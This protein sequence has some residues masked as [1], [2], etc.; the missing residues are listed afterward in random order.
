MKKRTLR[1]L[2]NAVVIAILTFVIGV[3]GVGLY[4]IH[5]MDKEYT[6]LSQPYNGDE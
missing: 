2:S 1:I 5:K 6:E 4:K 3:I